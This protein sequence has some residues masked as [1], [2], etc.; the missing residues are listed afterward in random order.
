G[1]P[2]LFAAGDI[3]WITDTKTHEV[4][5]QLGSVALQAGEH[6]G[7]TIARRVSGAP[8]DPF[9]YV[10]KGSMAT[11]GR[12]VAVVQLRRGRTIEGAPAMLAWGTVHLALL[13]SAEDRLKS[14]L[15]WIWAGF[16]RGRTARITLTEA[17]RPAEAPRPEVA[18][19][20]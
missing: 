5:P 20:R 6:V 13:P 11:I 15:S 3:A 19:R 18:P 4:L 10:D 17:P 1:H 2:E 14:L 16:T 9:V 12:G 7:E 8:P